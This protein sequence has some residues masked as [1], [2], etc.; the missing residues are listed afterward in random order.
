VKIVVS[1]YRDQQIDLASNCH[2]RQL[3]GFS[4]RERDS[5]LQFF[6]VMLTAIEQGAKFPAITI[7]LL[8]VLS[9]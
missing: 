6:R 3:I 5:L 4:E 7:L 8:G 2:I 9:F 1:S